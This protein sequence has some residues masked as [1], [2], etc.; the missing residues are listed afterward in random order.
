MCRRIFGWQLQKLVKNEEKFFT[1]DEYRVK[2]DCTVTPKPTYS[3]NNADV[4]IM[5]V[6]ELGKK[7]LSIA[8][9]W[10]YTCR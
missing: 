5:E 3:Y 10:I 6:A 7:N 9:I 4:E 2:R 1:F 8:E